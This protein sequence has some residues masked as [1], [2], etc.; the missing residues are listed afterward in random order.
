MP[1][2]KE[3]LLL[4]VAVAAVGWV[5]LNRAVKTK[6]HLEDP[7]YPEDEHPEES[8]VSEE[9]QNQQEP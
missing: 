9:E 5:I 6:L 2:D 1:L 7:D 3:Y 4:T 8:P